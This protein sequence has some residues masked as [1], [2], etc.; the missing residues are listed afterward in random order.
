MTR[1][2]WLVVAALLLGLVFALQA[3]E[4]STWNWLTL[5]RQVGEERAAIATLRTEID[6]LEALTRAVERDPA[7]QERIAREKYGMIR[8]GEFLYRVVPADTE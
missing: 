4:F 8:K 5:R 2:R 7:T 3:G 1:T 6:S